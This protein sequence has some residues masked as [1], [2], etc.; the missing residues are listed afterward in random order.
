MYLLYIYLIFVILICSSSNVFIL[1]I[2]KKN[3]NLYITYN[4]YNNTHS[5]IFLKLIIISEYKKEDIYD[6]RTVSRNEFKRKHSVF[7]NG[8][9]LPMVML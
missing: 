1:I 3:I 4:T 7:D 9:Y 8:N 5:I 6:H 2:I